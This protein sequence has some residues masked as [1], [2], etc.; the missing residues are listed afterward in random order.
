MCKQTWPL[1]SRKVLYSSWQHGHGTMWLVLRTRLCP[2]HHL[3]SLQLSSY[4]RPDEFYDIFLYQ[5]DLFQIIWKEIAQIYWQNKKLK[6]KKA[7]KNLSHFLPTS[8]VIS[9]IKYDLWDIKFH[10]FKNSIILGATSILILPQEMSIGSVHWTFE[11]TSQSPV[12]VS[13]VT[14][15]NL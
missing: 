4:H 7:P 11:S 2:T 1:A 9:K 6:S 14:I 15:W 3:C 8:K 5:Y 10:F 12:D 13:F